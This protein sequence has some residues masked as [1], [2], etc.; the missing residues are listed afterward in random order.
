MWGVRILGS[1]G[2]GCESVKLSIQLCIGSVGISIAIRSLGCL[3]IGTVT[4]ACAPVAADVDD[5]ALVVRWL[6]NFLLYNVFVYFCVCVSFV[7]TLLSIR[8]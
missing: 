7:Q 5:K 4:V 1:G 6:V 8:S 2:D 3:S